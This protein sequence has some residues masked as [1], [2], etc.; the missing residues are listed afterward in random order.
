MNNSISIGSNIQQN[1]GTIANIKVK[2][3]LLY[4]D[5]KRIDI[6]LNELNATNTN[7]L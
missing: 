2:N 3:N 7:L 1:F 4:Q 6:N 5:I